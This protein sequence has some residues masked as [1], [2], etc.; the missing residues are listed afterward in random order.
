MEIRLTDEKI[1]QL[2]EEPKMLIE[3]GLLGSFRL[4]RGHSE[5][6]ICAVGTSGAEYTIIIRKN[7]EDPLDFSVILGYHLP[8]SSDDRTRDATITILQFEKWGMQFHSIG[9]FEDQESI[10]RRVLARFSDIVGKQYSSL[11]SN[12]ERIGRYIR[13]LAGLSQG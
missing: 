4:K 13:E 7:K 1:A 3:P 5:C 2:I 11:R 8:G 6:D 9:I 10:N 12:E